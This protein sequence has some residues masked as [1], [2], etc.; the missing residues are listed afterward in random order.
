MSVNYSLG[1]GKPL[2][3][4]EQNYVLDRKLLTV[5]S[6][7]RDVS[8][9][10]YSNEFEIMLPQ[11]LQ[12]IQSMRLV[13]FEAPPNLYVFSNLYQNTAMDISY[14]TNTTT[15]AVII[16]NGTYTALQLTQMLQYQLPSAAAITVRYDSVS[17]KFIFTSANKF[18]FRFDQSSLQDYSGNTALMN[19][20][21][22]KGMP[23]PQNIYNQPLNWGLGYYLGFNKSVY[24]SITTPSLTYYDASSN[25]ILNTG[26]TNYII[27]DYAINIGGDKCIYMEIYKYN[28]YDELY[29]YNQSDFDH[30]SSTNIQLVN[31]NNSNSGRIN[32]AFAKIPL[33]KVYS[34]GEGFIL[35]SR[36]IALEGIKHFEPPLERLARFK[37]KFRFHDGRLVDFQQNSFNFTLEFNMLRNEIGKQYN[38]RIPSTYTL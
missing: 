20:L 10:P 13:E 29:P 11:Q 21:T 28:S 3:N 6:E 32:S 26:S 17:Q 38:V 12:N 24:S 1:A 8:K 5:H 19:C 14:N 27:S 9:Y 22:N 36:N 2:I 35:E 7:D 25:S 30:N 33:N 23:N 34:I 16:K 31:G 4:R 15:N 18:T 37:I